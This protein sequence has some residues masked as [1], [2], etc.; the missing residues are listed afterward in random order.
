MT[1]QFT[2]DARE[3]GPPETV[4]LSQ[5]YPAF[6]ALNLKNCFTAISDDVHVSR[7]M[8]VEIHH[9]PANRRI[10]GIFEYNLNA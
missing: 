7:S 2:L 8:I 10:V 9:N 3:V 4:I 5:P 1:F 6:P